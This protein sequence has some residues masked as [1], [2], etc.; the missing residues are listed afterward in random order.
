[1]ELDWMERLQVDAPLAEEHLELQCTSGIGAYQNFRRR[2]EDVLDLAHPDLA[3]ALRLDEVI[4]ARAAAAL[5]AVGQLADRQ[6]RYPGEQGA[7]LRTHPLRV[8]EM[9]GVVIDDLHLHRMTRRD[10]SE[11]GEE[12]GDVAHLLGHGHRHRVR[13]LVAEQ[14]PPLLHGRPAS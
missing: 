10:G 2:G 9:A 6:T 7:R 8:R 11:A 13:A 1:E 4:Y 3:R 5:I 14:A 12:L